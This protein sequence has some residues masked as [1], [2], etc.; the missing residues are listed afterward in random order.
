MSDLLHEIYRLK[1]A[2]V[3]GPRPGR[4][5]AAALAGMGLTHICSLLGEHEQPRAIESIANQLGLEWIWLPVPGGSLETLAGLDTEML[6]S[7]LA[8]A[9]AGTQAPRVYMHCSAGIHRTGFFASLLLRLQGF[10]ADEIPRALA[11]L[12]PVTAADVGDDRIALA[13]RRAETLSRQHGKSC[14]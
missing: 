11:T 12:R 7:S 8:Q 4:K 9:I 13:R 6:V 5:S 14:Q 10:T 1:G 2:I 3:L